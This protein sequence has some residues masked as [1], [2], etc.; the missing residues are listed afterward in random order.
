MGISFDHYDEEEFKQSWTKAVA[1]SKRLFECIMA[2]QPHDLENTLSLHQARKLLVQFSNP[3]AERDKAQAG[4]KNQEIIMSILTD[5]RRHVQK[6]Q[7]E[8]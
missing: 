6:A 4:A 8:Y 2:R 5:I 3:I 7:S 1:E